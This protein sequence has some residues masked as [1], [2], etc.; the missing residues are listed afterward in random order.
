[1]RLPL[2]VVDHVNGRGKDGLVVGHTGLVALDLADGVGVR[3]GLVVLELGEV[4]LAVSIVGD[5][6]LGVANELKAKLVLLELRPSSTLMAP[7][8][9]AWA[10]RDTCW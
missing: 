10:W 6:G 8:K 4:D 1:M 2:A 7:M 3:T 9:P 5:G